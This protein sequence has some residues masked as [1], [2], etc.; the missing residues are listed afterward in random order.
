[1]DFDPRLVSNRARKRRSLETDEVDV[2]AVR[3]QRMRVIL[4]AGASTQISEGNDSGS[5]SGIGG[6]KVT[7]ILPAMTVVPKAGQQVR[8][9]PLAILGRRSNVVDRDNF[10]AQDRARLGNRASARERVFRTRHAYDGWRHAAGRH[11]RT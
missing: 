1:M 2:Q 7:S 4:H 5:H 9:D 3:R 8:R 6:W 10:L 11:P